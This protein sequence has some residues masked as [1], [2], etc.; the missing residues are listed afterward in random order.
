M[1]LGRRAAFALVSFTLAAALALALFPVPA[2]ASAVTLYVTSGSAQVTRAGA[3]RAAID[4]EQIL[5]GDAVATSADG[6]VVLSFVDGSTLTLEPSTRVTVEES[7]AHPTSSVTRIAQSVGRTWSSVQRIATPRSRYEVSTPSL[8]ATV[9]G[10]AFEIDVASDGATRVHTVEGAVAVANPHGEVLVPA[11]T[12]TTATPSTAPAP[13]APPPAQPRRVVEIG[14]AATVVRDD[15]GRSCGRTPNG[16]VQQ[17]PGCVVQGG[18]IVIVGTAAERRLTSVDS[19]TAPGLV[20]ATPPPTPAV[21]DVSLPGIGVVPVQLPT[22]G[23][24]L[25]PAATEPAP[26]ARL[27]VPTL[28]PLPTSAPTI[29]IT[30]LPAVVP[31]S[32]PAPVVTAAPTVVPTAVPTVA[33]TA[34]PTTVPTAVPTIAPTPLPTAAPAPIPTPVPTAVP[35]LAVP[36]LAVPTLAPTA[37]PT[38]FASPAPSPAAAPVEGAT[39]TPAPTASPTPAPTPTPT[40]CPTVLGV[41]VC[42][43]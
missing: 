3:A 13:V 2:A 28:P 42:L 20:V 6:H 39:P 40:E 38:L 8:T 18:T 30:P 11:G 22:F 15:A 23:P 29:A 9:R 21:T 19:A 37:A 27:A 43:P 32:T 4:G 25:A 12:Q 33:P 36:T 1:R 10:T 16:V 35:T 31:T 7:S 26:P 17:I 24:T 41:R 5:A 34:V 14:T